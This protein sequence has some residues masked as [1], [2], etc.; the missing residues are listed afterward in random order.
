M[1]KTFHVPA[2]FGNGCDQM[3]ESLKFEELCGS[4]ARASRLRD[5]WNTTYQSGTA[6][7]HLMGQPW[8]RTKEDNFRRK[9]LAEGFTPAQIA[10]FMH[11]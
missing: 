10:A 1:S 2:P 11:L 8:A 7:D 9:A 6:Y 3:A 5:L 4:I